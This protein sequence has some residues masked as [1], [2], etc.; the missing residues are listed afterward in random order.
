MFRT[1][2]S[3][4]SASRFALATRHFQTASQ[5][6]FPYKNTQDKDTIKTD[7]NEYSKSGGDGAAARQTEDIAFNPDK[8]SPEE[9]H[10]AAS[11][12]MG[13][14]SNNP[15][16]VSPANTEI[17]KPRGEQEG[18]AQGSPGETGQGSEQRSKTSGGGSAQKSG[19]GKSGGGPL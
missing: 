17:G 18:G 9:Q 1:I 15:L 19:G 16:N 6:Q 11:R 12:K 7:S 4:P 13:G 14:D 3:R 8:T 5:R 10:D 2:P